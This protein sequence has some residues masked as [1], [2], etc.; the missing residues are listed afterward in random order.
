MKLKLALRFICLGLAVCSLSSCALVETVRKAQLARK[1]P[2]TPPTPVAPALFEWKGDDV[3]GPTSVQIALSEQ[4]A[5][6]Y[7]GG[8]EVGW[9]Y[10]ATGTSSHP[11]P[12]G[13]YRVMEK[14]A[15]KRS[16]RWGRIVNANGATIDGEARSGR[17]A[18]PPGGR[19]VGAPMPHWMRLTGYGIGMHGG[20]IPYPGRT[21][22]HGCI[23]LPFEMAGILF[24]HVEVGT[25]V[26]IRQ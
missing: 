14:V 21:A 12:A 26:V 8:E 9:T 2:P 5:R 19:F 13:A 20:P 25:P 24:N 22:S 17:E 3:Q 4:K 6:I 1:T 10:V 7:K 18:I 15:D 16:N 23:R 11:T